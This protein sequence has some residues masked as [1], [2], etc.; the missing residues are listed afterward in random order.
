MIKVAMYSVLFGLVCLMSLTAKPSKKSLDVRLVNDK[1]TVYVSFVRS[2][3]RR[4]LENW[5]SDQGVWLRIHNNTKWNLVF[6]AG[7]V[8]DPSYGD[9]VMFYRIKRIE[10][11]GDVPVGYQ[12][13]VSSVIQLQ[14][15]RSLE[16]S[17]PREHLVQG[18]AID[19]AFNYEWELNKERTLVRES[20]PRHYVT[21]ESSSVR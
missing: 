9:A 5:E 17:V 21:F 2:G 11:E 6:N 16:F 3:P 13:H 15:G 7:G 1:P 20:E 14:S 12:R 10:G 18:L 4:P 8:P 19:I